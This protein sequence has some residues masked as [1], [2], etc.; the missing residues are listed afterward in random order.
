MK[1]SELEDCPGW[2]KIAKTENADVEILNGF[3][4]WNS[5]TWRSG[6]WEEGYWETGTWINGIWKD[7]IWK[8]GTW[9][10]GGWY[11][12]TWERGTWHNGTWHNGLWSDGIWK[13][14]L[15]NRGVWA[16]GVWNSKALQT[17]RFKYFPKLGSD[18]YISIGCQ[19]KTREEWDAWF[20]GDEIFSTPRGTETFDL[21]EANYKAFIAYAE[22]LKLIPK[23]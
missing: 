21:I 13:G 11:G 22:H 5:G 2:L 14:G 12:G 4:H 10:N 16:G 15:W 1:I 18:K 23:K 8:N 20:A 19:T 9:E 17:I 3:V 6:I 7:G